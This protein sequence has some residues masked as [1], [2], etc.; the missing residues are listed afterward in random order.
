MAPQVEQEILIEAPVDAV[1]RVVTEPAYIRQWFAETVD[2]VP[3][4]GYAGELAFEHLTIQV[5]VQSVQPERLLSYRWL[6][7]ADA[8]PVEGNSVLVE[9]TL[10]P[11]RAGTLLRVVETG[12]DEMHWTGDVLSTYVAEHNEGWIIFLGRLRD[13]LS[14]TVLR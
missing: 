12:L 9:L 7:Q 2:L 3:E 14:R 6:H 1:W 11:N 5:R 10:R 8:T 13:L 4:P